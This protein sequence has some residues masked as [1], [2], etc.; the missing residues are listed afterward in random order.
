MGVEIIVW[1]NRGEEQRDITLR[2]LGCI[3]DI[4]SDWQF[5]DGQKKKDI[6]D[7]YVVD[8]EDRFRGCCADGLFISASVF[9]NEG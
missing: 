4:V 7:G 3:K 5:R 2:N 1:T 6:L 8:N 9:W